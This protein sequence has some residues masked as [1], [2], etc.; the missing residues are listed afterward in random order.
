MGEQLLKNEFVDALGGL[1]V[2]FTV[3]DLLVAEVLSNEVSEGLQRLE[4]HVIG[5]RLDFLDN[6]RQQTLENIF[7]IR[8]EQLVV[9]RH[10]LQNLKET[11]SEFI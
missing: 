10:L 11:G 9:L 8:N 5:F 2:L 7:G 1:V 6:N 4:P 3:V